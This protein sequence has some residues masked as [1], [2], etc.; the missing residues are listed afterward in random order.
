MKRKPAAK[1][2]VKIRKPDPLAL[3]GAAYLMMDA[4]YCILEKD[5]A[6]LTPKPGAPKEDLAER[7][8][9]LYRDQL[10]RWSLAA[11]TLDLRAEALRRAMSPAA[12]GAAAELSP[13]AKREIAALLA[14]AE[15]EPRDPRGVASSW[16]SRPG[17][18]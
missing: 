7:F 8:R 6:T 5:G 12:A 10:A 1:I 15:S 4:A 2:S 13:Q 18:R 11:A 17:K 9:V 14:E 16:D 3:S